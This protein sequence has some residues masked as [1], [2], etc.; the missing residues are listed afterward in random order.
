MT[1][2]TLIFDLD[3]TVIDST[4]RTPYFENGDLDLTSYKAMQTR[5]NIFRDKL[6]PLA[7]TMKKEYKNGK[8]I[9]ILT[10]RQMT[11]SDYDFLNFHNLQSHMILSRNDITNEHFNL[12]DSDYKLRHLKIANIDVKTAIMYDDNKK[13]KSLL[14]K[15]GL[16]V[17]CA[18]KINKK[19]AKK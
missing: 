14:R 19:L 13:V 4:H 18:I 1:I 17:Q 8:N 5:K 7:K 11:K 16:T 9:I 3:E 10:A 12:T 2:K 6:L 15:N